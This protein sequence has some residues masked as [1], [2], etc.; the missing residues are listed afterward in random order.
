MRG[1]HAATPERVTQ[2]WSLDSKSM[3]TSRDASTARARY[4]T[5][6]ALPAAEW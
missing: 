3:R 6:T 4:T 1:S 5:V 2:A